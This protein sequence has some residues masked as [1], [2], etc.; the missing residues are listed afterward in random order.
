M[1]LNHVTNKKPLLK[2]VRVIPVSIMVLT[3]VVVVGSL[4]NQYVIESKRISERKTYQEFIIDND[5]NITPP[6]RDEYI[7]FPKEITLN[8]DMI[9]LICTNPNHET[10]V[11]NNTMA[12]VVMCRCINY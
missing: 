3:T 2:K 6:C 5:L 9:S 10:F 11:E 12:N 4:I 8:N 7:V 1:G